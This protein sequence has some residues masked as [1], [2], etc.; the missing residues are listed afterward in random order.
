MEKKKIITLFGPTSFFSAHSS[1]LSAWPN[2]SS[3]AQATG[4]HMG[5]AGQPLALAHTRFRVTAGG[6]LVSV[7]TV[8]PRFL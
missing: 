1:T 2:S 5:P 4:S 3:R 6:A 8:A 7:Y